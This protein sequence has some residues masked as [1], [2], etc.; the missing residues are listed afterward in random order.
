[1]RWVEVEEVHAYKRDLF[2]TDLICLA[3]KK[4][5][6][7]EYFEIHEEWE[8]YHDLLNLLPI[9]LPQFTLQW[10]FAVAVPAFE[11]NHQIIWKRSPDQT[12]R[13][14]CSEA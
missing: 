14:V 3:F 5:G 6:S 2:T 12:L 11:A 13:E 7:E 4:V 10:I 8:G 1:L 9:R